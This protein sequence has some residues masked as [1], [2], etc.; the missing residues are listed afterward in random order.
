MSEPGRRAG[1]GGREPGSV[2][3]ITVE[4]RPGR[5]VTARREGPTGAGRAGL[6]LA[7]G[8][9]AGQG[10]P[11]LSGLRRRLARAGYPVMTFDYPYQAEGRRAPD[12]MEALAACHRAVADVLA[13]E[14][15]ELVLAGKSMG[16]RVASHLVAGGYPCR[17]VVCYG[18]PLIPP[19]GTEPR[20][21]SHLEA[22]AVPLLFLAGSRDPLA[23]LDLLRPVVERLP[24]AALVVLEGGDHSF[25]VKTPPGDGGEAVLDRLAA[26]TVEWLAGQG[27]PGGGR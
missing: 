20:D 24:R 7:P 12:R 21:T 18:Y 11:F 14:V 22:V 3:Q 5:R 9:G 6:L 25:G 26:A 27:Q 15:G 8:A 13:G 23:P 17:A 2:R 10:H 1:A 19:G 4:W 16:S